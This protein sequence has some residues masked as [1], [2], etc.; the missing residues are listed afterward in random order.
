MSKKD[1]YTILGVDKTANSDEIKKSY[2][3]LAKELHPDK[4]PN[5]KEAEER[6]KEVSVA[7]EHLSDP[8]KK[9]KYDQFGHVSQRQQRPSYDFTHQRQVR[10]GENMNLLV[11]LTLEELYTG[12]IKRYKY[13]RNEKCDICDGHG[14]SDSQECP[15]CNGMGFMV[16]MHNTPF[17][18]ATTVVPC[19]MCQSDGILYKKQCVPCKGSGLKTKE[20]TIEITIP[21]GMQEGMPVYMEGKGHAVKNGVCGD[22]HIHIQEL[23]H[24]VFMRNGSDLKMTLKLTYSQLV[25]GDKIE[26]ETIDGGKIRVTIP[27]HSDVGATLKVQN[28]GMKDYNKE[29]RG[30][31]LIN[32]GI[33]IPKQISE[34]TRELLTKLKNS[35]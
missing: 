14:G 31:V 12:T 16:R 9:A 19:R 8:V 6:F 25:L 13:N 17:G 34:T 26:L 1:Y 28:K 4:N 35:L 11:K 32:L 22:L 20:E 21:S 15:T 30:D 7:Y 18:P 10:R 5:N 3:K 2:R 24:K 23:P 29:T 27:E 33:D